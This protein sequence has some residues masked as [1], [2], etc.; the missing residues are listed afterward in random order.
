MVYAP[1]WKD[2]FYTSTAD[3]LVYKIKVSNNYIFQGKAYKMPNAQNL[4]ICVN[5]ICENFLFQDI[6]LI[7]TGATTQTS[8]GACLNFLLQNEGGITL[9]TYRFLYDWDYGHNWT[10]SYA[11]LSIPINGHYAS[12]QMKL[13]SEVSSAG[14]VGT[15]ST[16]TTGYNKEVCGDY[17]LHYVNARGG[18]DSFVF[19]GLCTKTDTISDHYFNKSFVN[20]TKE[21]GT[22]RYI[23]EINTAYKLNTGILS[24]DEAALFAKHLI[25]SN[26]CYLQIL[27]EGKIIPVVITDNNAQYKKEGQDDVITY[28]VNVKE[29]Q[30]KIRR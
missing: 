26:K 10:G 17:I 20:T 21:F 24:E 29:S 22:G 4:S 6:D 15:T 19:E 3:T 30:E 11:V 28:E 12:G 1:I 14:V 13:R 9:Q 23:S 7:L 27:S 8:S 25:G 18:W 16:A 5:R 2:T